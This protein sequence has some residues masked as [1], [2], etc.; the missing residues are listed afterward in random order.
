[1]WEIIRK[2]IGARRVFRE[3]KNLFRRRKTMETRKILTIWIL[4]LVLV[5][6]QAR[7]SEATPMSTAFTYQGH[8]YDVNHVANGLYDFAFK[9]YDAKVTGSKVGTDVNVADVNVIDAFFT[10]EL[11]FNDLDA[12]NGD[13]RW[14]EISVRPGEQNDPCEYTVLRPRQEVTPTPYALYAKT[15]G[16][17]GSDSDW[18]ISGVDMYSGVSGNVGV[19]TTSPAAK[20]HIGGTAGVD[21]LMF[22]DG[23][24]QTTAAAGGDITAVNAGYGLNG[25][26]TSGDVTLGVEV[27]FDLEGKYQDPIISA[28]NTGEG[29]AL[30]G[31]ASDP[32]GVGV[33]GVGTGGAKAGLFT[34]DIHVIENIT[35]EYTKATASR[36]IPIAY[37]FVHSDATLDA[38]TPNVS[39]V[40]NAAKNR[41]EI[42]IYDETYVWDKYVT[43]VTVYSASPL[44]SATTSSEGGKLLVH[45]WDKNA[46]K[47]QQPFQFVTFKP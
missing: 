6:S 2:S 7:V 25:G 18:T 44:Y 40:W 22:P 5:V 15:A 23:T 8:L 14:L 37:S 46:D 41:F 16:T 35:K 34:G 10:V 12:F 43:V 30:Y 1:L 17:S 26:G 3:N 13:A 20:L 28:T 45:I 24:L 31:Y 42:T 9:L 27:P 38:N 47:A 21:G 4:A 11:D 39:A 29:D 32:N 19:G 33:H 36:A